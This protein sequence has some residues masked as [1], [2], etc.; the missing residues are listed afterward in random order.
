MFL[1]HIA[2]PIRKKNDTMIDSTLLKRTQLCF[3]YNVQI[4]LH[5][6][7]TISS[8][9]ELNNVNQ[10]GHIVYKDNNLN[11]FFLLNKRCSKMNDL[12]ITPF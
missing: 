10:Q 8:C 3:Y 7:H 11:L 12:I 2:I 9:E 6:I 4:N 1:K 5:I